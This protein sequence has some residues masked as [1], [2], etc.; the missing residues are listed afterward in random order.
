MHVRVGQ[1][2]LNGHPSKKAVLGKRTESPGRYWYWWVLFLCSTVGYALLL[3]YSYRF[4]HW[5]T[6]FEE[7]LERKQAAAMQPGHDSKE[8][9]AGEGHNSR[10]PSK[11]DASTHVLRI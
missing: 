3:Y 8:L 1:E 7:E 10:E 6:A 2:R 5:K 4:E 11:G 9:A